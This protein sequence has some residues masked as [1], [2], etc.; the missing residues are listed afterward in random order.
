MVIGTGD[1]DLVIEMTVYGYDPVRITY[2]HQ[3]TI[4]AVAAL[5]RV[6]SDDVG[7]A[8][9][10][11]V[12]GRL[13]RH[14]EDEWMPALTAIRVSAAMVAWRSTISGDPVPWPLDGLLG[15]VGEALTALSGL[16]Q[17]STAQ[18]LRA[19]DAA[20]AAFE[21]A[22]VR[23]QGD[24]VTAWQDLHLHLVELARRIDE[25]GT[26]VG[27]VWRSLGRDG[28]TAIVRW[29]AAAVDLARRDLTGDPATSAERTTA[30]A[31]GSLAVFLGALCGHDR[32]GAELV[33]ELAR[34]STVVAEAAAVDPS[35][36]ETDVLVAIA[37]SLLSAMTE[38]HGMPALNAHELV[39]ATGAALTALASRPSAALDFVLDDDRL[40][41]IVTS[42]WLLDDDVERF[43]AG[44]LLAPRT[45]PSRMAD[46]LERLA[47]IAAIPWNAEL[48]AG[49]RRGLAIGI[50]PYLD[51]LTTQ[52]HATE[53]PRLILATEQRTVEFGPRARFTG[54]IG[55]VVDDE[56]AQ[57]V[58]GVTMSAY[59]ADRVAAATETLRSADRVG[60]DASRDLV[61]SAL[62]DVDRHVDTVREAI[63]DQNARHAFQHALSVGRTKVVIDVATTALSAF[64]PVSKG[65]GATIT[66]ASQLLSSAIGWGGPARVPQT[67]L[68]EEQ[69]RDAEVAFLRVPL[70]HADLRESLDLASVDAATWSE[71][72]GLVAELDE[73]VDPAR[74][75]EIAARLHAAM[76]S[77]PWLWSYVTIVEDMTGS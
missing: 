12:S 6:R 67:S 7:A 8:D 33:V 17:L 5:V 14:L 56:R 62:R 44:V 10:L 70:E 50:G 25:D 36:F 24:T 57:L 42:H 39:R 65:A 48:N 31:T 77:D 18:L 15:H 34:S 9:A 35:W 27:I 38:L 1:R 73:T 52:L 37:T 68:F 43:V 46:G 64:G 26:V 72:G 28:V 75:A 47:S 13:R 63:T 4:A 66:V 30:A 29:A 2:L 54:L 16:Q 20:G 53:A 55:R 41:T 22:A 74:R 51:V 69:E 19:L 61:V 23:G 21:D 40:R 58:L 45:D 32:D 11:R 49:T 59:R 3:R 60:P 76:K 71:V